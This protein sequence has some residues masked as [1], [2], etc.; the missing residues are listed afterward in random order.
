MYTRVI[1]YLVLLSIHA[2]CFGTTYRISPLKAGDWVTSGQGTV[3]FVLGPGTPPMGVAS[4][5]LAS[6]DSGAFAKLINTGIARTDVIPIKQVVSLTYWTWTE[7]SVNHSNPESPNLVIVVAPN[8]RG[9][10]VPISED[11]FASLT[12]PTPFFFQPRYQAQEFWTGSKHDVPP[13]ELR[14]SVVMREWQLWDARRGLW[15]SPVLHPGS[16]PD[17]DSTFLKTFDELFGLAGPSQLCV[18]TNS[19]GNGIRL[20]VGVENS[21]PDVEKRRWSK[22]IGNVDLFGIRISSMPDSDSYNFETDRPWWFYALFLLPLLAIPIWIW[23]T[24]VQRA[25]QSDLSA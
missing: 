10:K 18:L 8:K 25:R 9:C 24:R 20:Q 2:S 6:T 12:G 13:P 17:Q 21:A 3:E 7:E 23:R 22:F 19:N 4:A 1:S 14:Q 11:G 16:S 5:K 15:W